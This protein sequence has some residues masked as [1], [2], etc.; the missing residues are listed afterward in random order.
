M[1]MGKGNDSYIKCM[2]IVSQQWSK[3]IFLAISSYQYKSM[4]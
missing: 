3:I 1:A 4:E 2:E